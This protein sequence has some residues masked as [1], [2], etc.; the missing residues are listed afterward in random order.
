MK[1]AISTIYPYKSEGG[2]FFD[3]PAIGVVREAFVSGADDVM[4]ALSGGDEKFKMTFSH[5]PFPGYEFKFDWCGAEYD[6]NW[7]EGH[8]MRGWLCSVLLAYFDEAPKSIYL[9]VEK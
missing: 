2:W 6:G 7:Y 8:G 1:N 3:D 5:S 4:E 9:Q